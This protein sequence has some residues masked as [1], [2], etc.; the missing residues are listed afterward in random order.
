MER[1]LMFSSQ[2]WERK[3]SKKCLFVQ[4]TARNSSARQKPLSPGRIPRWEMK[5]RKK[6]LDNLKDFNPFRSHF[7]FSS[8][9]KPFKQQ[10]EALKSG[11]THWPFKTI[12]PNFIRSSAWLGIIQSVLQV[13]HF[14]LLELLLPR[15]CSLSLSLESWYPICIKLKWRRIR[16]LGFSLSYYCRKMGTTWVIYHLRHSLSI[17]PAQQVLF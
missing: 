13:S 17:P 15:F 1:L 7:F 4:A 6:K 12:S 10:E 11:Q 14:I 5:G 8:R 2:L 16:R 9:K 3:F